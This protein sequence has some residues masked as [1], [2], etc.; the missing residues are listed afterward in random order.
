MAQSA[1]RAAQR[2]QCD[3]VA[4]VQSPPSNVRWAS[5]SSNT[6][7]MGMRRVESSRKGSSNQPFCVNVLTNFP[8][9]N[10]RLFGT[11]FL[12]AVLPGSWIFEIRRRIPRWE[13]LSPG[14]WLYIRMF[15]LPGSTFLRA[16]PELSLSAF[17]LGSSLWESRLHF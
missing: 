9:E 10:E 1:P 7:F 11:I 13:Q 15:G 8:L 4:S 17:E 12:L 3:D 2:C 5:E 14:V 6:H 16:V